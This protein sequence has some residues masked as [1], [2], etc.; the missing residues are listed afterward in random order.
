MNPGSYLWGTCDVWRPGPQARAWRAW[1]VSQPLLEIVH[2]QNPA[3]AR[4]ILA[5]G[6]GR[7]EL[8]LRTY[9]GGEHGESR[10][11]GRGTRGLEGC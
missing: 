4:L 3:A 11:A 2:F 9:G 5:N 10:G 1:V 6:G 8:F 7:G